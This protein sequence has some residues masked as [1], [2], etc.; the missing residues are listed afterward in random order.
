MWARRG[1][2]IPPQVS[3]VK[4]TAVWR[5]LFVWCVCPVGYAPDAEYRDGFGRDRWVE[6]TRPSTRGLCAAVDLLRR[7]RR[8]WRNSAPSLR[9]SDKLTG[10]LVWI[11]GCHRISSFRRFLPGPSTNYATVSIRLRTRS[12]ASPSFNRPATTTRIRKYV[13]LTTSRQR[14]LS[15]RLDF[16]TFGLA[17]SADRT[18]GKLVVGRAV[19]NIIIRRIIYSLDERFLFAGHVTVRVKRPTPRGAPLAFSARF[20]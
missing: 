8:T 16:G 4:R 2:C 12:S 18:T 3:R 7:P 5:E 6:Y 17:C 1:K 9:V 14:S 19:R 10:V 15:V 20:S 11:R 13:R